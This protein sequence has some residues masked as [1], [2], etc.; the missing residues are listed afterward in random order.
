MRFLGGA[1]RDADGERYDPPNGFDLLSNVPRRG[2]TR[3]E[4]EQAPPRTIVVYSPGSGDTSRAEGSVFTNGRIG[5]REAR[6]GEEVE[7][8][9]ASVARPGTPGA[10]VPLR[11]Q[12]RHA[13][14]GLGLSVRD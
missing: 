11:D 10:H 7:E 14:R 1:P 8:I 2:A 4:C 9:L 5:V 12:R 13:H 3:T 6:N